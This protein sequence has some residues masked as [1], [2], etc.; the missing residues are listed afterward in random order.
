[1][2]EIFQPYLLADKVLWTDAD[3][4]DSD[5]DFGYENVNCPSFN[6]SSKDFC[7]GFNDALFTIIARR[8]DPPEQLAGNQ[9]FIFSSDIKGI[10]G[11]APL[12]PVFLQ[13]AVQLVRTGG[14]LDY[15][16]ESCYPSGYQTPNTLIPRDRENYPYLRESPRFSRW[17]R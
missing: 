7:R 11:K 15:I 1:M 9:G 5:F 12:Q 13:C 8:P 14:R 3:T 4:F 2:L 10:Y 16:T 6:C 17:R